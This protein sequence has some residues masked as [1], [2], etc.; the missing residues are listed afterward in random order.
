MIP[1]LPPGA[2]TSENPPLPP[3]AI[4]SEGPPLPPGAIANGAE[5]TSWGGGKADASQNDAM[6]ND[7]LDVTEDDRKESMA[8]TASRHAAKSIAPSA[9]AYVGAQGG[10]MLGA[11]TGPAAPVAAPALALVGGI[12]SYLIAAHL[13]DAS[14]HEL[15]Y[16]VQREMGLSEEQEEKGDTENFWS[17]VGGDFALAAPAI[18]A[19]VAKGYKAGKKLASSATRTKLVQGGMDLIS[20]IGGQVKETQRNLARLMNEHYVKKA[21]EHGKTVE[22]I[23]AQAEQHSHDIVESVHGKSFPS[24]ESAYTSPHERVEGIVA[25]S[26]EEHMATAEQA[27]KEAGK[28]IANWETDF[29]TKQAKSGAGYDFKEGKSFRA[30]LASLIKRGAKVKDN[31]DFSRVNQLFQQEIRQ[32]VNNIQGQKITGS[33]KRIPL[34]AQTLSRE[35]KRLGRAFAAAPKGSDKRVYLGE[36]RQMLVESMSKFSS[37]PYPAAAYALSMERFAELSRRLGIKSLPGTSKR[38]G[39]RLFKMEGKA[40]KIFQSDQNFR[41]FSELI[42]TGP[43]TLAAEQHVANNIQG[44]TSDQIIKW[45]NTQKWF[46]VNPTIRGKLETYVGELARQEGNLK[47]AQK[48][49]NDA[50]EMVTAYKQNIP[51]IGRDRTEHLDKIEQILMTKHGEKMR[52]AW[53]DIRG[54][55]KRV[56]TFDDSEL[57]TMDDQIAQISKLDDASDRRKRLLSMGA[58]LL[59][60]GVAERALH[61][62]TGLL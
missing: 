39:P 61:K 58:G 4:M 15:P 6:W 46:D 21:A 32:V 51:K 14:I 29:Q 36:I 10:A 7:I 45:M 41:N 47:N 50:Q 11:M 55:L 38:V 27:R 56:G 48:L 28:E 43:A 22:E 54:E 24:A 52:D 37:K 18:G 20:Q 62:L 25:R 34:D 19:G 59:G 8:G 42:G 23:A 1:P 3:G 33:K 31:K 12:G 60:L 17:G 13:Q 40:T 57:K 53:G 2:I 44:K 35:I 30:Q 5:D 16:K 26:V 49:A 9:A